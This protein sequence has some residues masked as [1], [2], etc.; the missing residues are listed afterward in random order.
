MK[1]TIYFSDEALAAVA[2]DERGIEGLSGRVG[3]LLTVASA[4]EK[5]AC[6]ALLKNEW[7]ALADANN[8]TAVEYSFGFEHPITGVTLNLADA[9]PDLD[10][11]WQVSCVDLARRIRAMPLAQQFAVFEVVRRFWRTPSEGVTG[12]EAFLARVGA[13][14]EGGQ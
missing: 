10:E 3:F 8:G 5:E 2:P 1:K 9:A 11:K 13:K 6:P 12:W 7:L 14:V 4:I